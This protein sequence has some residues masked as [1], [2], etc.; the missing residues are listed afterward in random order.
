M[1]AP[2]PRTR[3]RSVSKA[4]G[5]LLY[6]SQS[7][8]GARGSDVAAACGL[9][10]PTAHH[11]LETLLAEGFLS[12]DELRR[13]H[14]GPKVG[15]LSDAF[16]SRTQPP[17]FLMEPLRKLAER[18]G[19]TAY[20]SGW[21]HGDIAV[22]ATV[23]GSRAVRVAGLHR[24]SQ[25]HAH[26]RASGKL[27]L[28]YARPGVAEA[29]LS[30]APLAA[31][32]SRTITDPDALLAELETIRRRGSATDLEEYQDRV[33]CVAAPVIDDGVVIAAYTLSVPWDRFR[34]DELELTRAVVAA[35]GEAA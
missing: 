9:P 28:A 32:T 16:L 31:L 34:N 30:R 14:L 4:L 3:V 8:D 5:I 7:S 1:K 19:E 22:L 23:E 21:L 11:L 17:E 20:L 13:Y 2:A 33:C 18:S 10:A 25:G 29:Y 35:A 15:A 6:V 24:G 12:K 26:A 27:L